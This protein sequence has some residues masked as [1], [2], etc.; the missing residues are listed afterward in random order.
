[1]K[2]HSSSAKHAGMS[3][4]IKSVHTAEQTSTKEDQ[5]KAIH[6]YAQTQ[7]APNPSKM[8]KNNQIPM[9]IPTWSIKDYRS[10]LA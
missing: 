2:R 7:N 5:I 4:D 1:M 10:E 8:K 9:T 6:T 3:F